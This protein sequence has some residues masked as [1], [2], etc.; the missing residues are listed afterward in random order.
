M[1]GIAATNQNQM[2]NFVDS[3]KTFISISEETQT[4]WDTFI[5]LLSSRFA[6]P[7]SESS[8][9][10]NPVSDLICSSDS[11]ISYQVFPNFEC[12][13][14][15]SIPNGVDEDKDVPSYW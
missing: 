2:H 11:Q 1:E 6:V 12:L 3:M 9:T 5:D 10:H 8:T 15:K 7:Q 13:E 14:D 4:K